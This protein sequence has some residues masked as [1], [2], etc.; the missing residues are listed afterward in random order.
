MKV[1]QRAILAYG[2]ISLALA[3]GPGCAS[4]NAKK[5]M[6]AAAAGTIAMAES[7]IRSAREAKADL[8]ASTQLSEA[9][10]QL[11]YARQK[12]QNKDYSAASKLAQTAGQ[13]AQEAK[14]KAE[15]SQKKSKTTKKK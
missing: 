10:S 11:V 5:E 7:Q 3:L 6:K 15:Q 13:S 1:T 4:M 9:E 12:L 2:F 8:Y 14:L